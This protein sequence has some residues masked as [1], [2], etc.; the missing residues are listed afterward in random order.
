MTDR[1]LDT[2]DEA[3]RIV[4]DGLRRMTPAQRVGR[5]VSLTVLAHGVALAQIRRDHP[6]ED[7]RRWRLRLA[8]RLYGPEL[9]KRAFDWPPG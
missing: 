3:W 6:D 1:P 7:D 8:A 2:S 4:N 9:I 5:V